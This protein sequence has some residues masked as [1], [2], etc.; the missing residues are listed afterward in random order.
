MVV[1]H[2]SH[3]FPVNC[4]HF[5]R[6]F[7][8]ALGIVSRRSK[9]GCPT[10]APAREKLDSLDLDS[11]TR[12]RRETTIRNGRCEA[13]KITPWCHHTWLIWLAGSHFYHQTIYKNITISD[14]PSQNL[15]NQWDF[16]ATCSHVWWHQR[17]W[18]SPKKET[19]WNGET[20]WNPTPTPRNI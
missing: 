3:N 16:P 12:R 8:L 14:F 9:T 18:G 11:A 13:V 5:L 1:H 10:V 7:P 17:V 15:Y 20:M 4:C 2:M 19:W 6:V